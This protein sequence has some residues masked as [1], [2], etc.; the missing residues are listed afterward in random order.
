VGYQKRENKG[1]QVKINPFEFHPDAEGGD[2]RKEKNFLT[3]EEIFEILDAEIE[4]I[5]AS[6]PKIW[7]FVRE[8]IL[9]ILEGL[10]EKV[11]ER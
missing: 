10:K 5:E 8:D 9:E 6:P 7:G 4:K 11:E 3:K 2:S 1:L